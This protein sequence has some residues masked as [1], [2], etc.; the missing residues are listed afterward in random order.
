M[1]SEFI[2]GVDDAH[3]TADEIGAT[4]PLPASGTF[5]DL[6]WNVA[7]AGITRAEMQTVMEYNAL[8]DWER[9]VEQRGEAT[10]TELRVIETVPSWP[11]FRGS[12]RAKPVLQVLEGLRNDDLAPLR[13]HMAANCRF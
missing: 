2:F 1:S 3:S 13:A 4:I 5:D 12:D 11:S 9:V 10:E 7:N 6:T 8:C